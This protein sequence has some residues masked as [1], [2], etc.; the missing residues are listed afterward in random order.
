[1]CSAGSLGCSICQ[2][3]P[4]DGI[5]TFAREIEIHIKQGRAARDG[6]ADLQETYVCCLCTSE[7]VSLDE[8]EIGSLAVRYVPMTQCIT[9]HRLASV[10][11]TIIFIK[12]ICK[13]SLEDTP[14]LK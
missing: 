8:A 11:I 13:L 9:A 1:M 6:L 2:A 10:L 4:G 12:F 14:C 5:I 7:A 3:T